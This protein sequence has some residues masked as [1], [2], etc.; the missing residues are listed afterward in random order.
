MK[1]L[2]TESVNHD[3][4]DNMTIMTAATFVFAASAWIGVFYIANIMSGLLDRQVRT[5]TRLYMVDLRQSYTDTAICEILEDRTYT[6]TVPCSRNCKEG[7]F[8]R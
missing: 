7:G 5:E 8:D 3:M 2:T 1:P 4:K 6:F